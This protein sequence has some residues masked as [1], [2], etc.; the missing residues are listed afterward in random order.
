MLPLQIDMR[1][2]DISPHALSVYESQLN[3]LQADLR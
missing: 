2:A 1:A 3:G